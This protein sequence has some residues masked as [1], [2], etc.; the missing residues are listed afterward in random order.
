MREMVQRLHC[1]SCGHIAE[2]GQDE[3]YCSNCKQSGYLSPYIPEGTGKAEVSAGEPDT[4]GR[5]QGGD[6]ERVVCW[7][8]G[9]RTPIGERL[10]IG[11]VPPAPDWLIAKLEP[12]FPGVSR[13]HAELFFRDDCLRIRDLGSTNGTYLNGVRLTGFEETPVAQGDQIGFGKALTIE[14]E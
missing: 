13:M 11:R 14:I 10:F 12:E 4:A 2:Y 8:W 3:I 1:E 5:W 7:P 9:E 6:S